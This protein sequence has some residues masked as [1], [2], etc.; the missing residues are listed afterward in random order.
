MNIVEYVSLLYIGA[1]SRYMPRSGI[2]GSSSSTMSSFL[3][4]QQIDFQ[5]GCT[6]LQSYHF[7]IP[8]IQFT[9]HMK[10]EDHSV[11]TLVLLRK[12]IKIPMVGNTET[13]FGAETAG[14]AIQ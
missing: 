8:K 5:S 3:R 14:K 12:G 9:D 13:K 10:K 2:A 11:D 7:R 4:N 1:S 6:G